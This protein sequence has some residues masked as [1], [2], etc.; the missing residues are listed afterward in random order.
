MKKIKNMSQVELAAYTFKTRC[1][2][3]E[4]K[5]CYLVE[6]LFLFTVAINTFPKI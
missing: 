2:Q 4:F 5:L 1:K 3:K 6:V